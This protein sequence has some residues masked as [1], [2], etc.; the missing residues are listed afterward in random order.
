MLRSLRARQLH[1]HHL[2]FASS[3]APR[4]A[5]IGT[6][7]LA[8]F[9]EGSGVGAPK[10]GYV[11][12]SFL[13]NSSVIL[14]TFQNLPE[15]Q[16]VLLRGFRVARILGILPKRLRGAAGPHPSLDTDHD[17][18]EPVKELSWTGSDTMVKFSD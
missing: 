16:C 5:S 7:Y 15:D 8:V 1:R 2:G 10:G 17:D 12:S 11:T 13:G 4:L 3:K 18:Y 6:A 9:E 14:R